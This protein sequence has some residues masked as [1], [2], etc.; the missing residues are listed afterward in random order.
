MFRITE[1]P[2][3]G[4]FIQCLAKNYS[5]GS[6]VSVDLDV[7]G[8][9]AAYCD[10]LCVCVCGCACVCLYIYFSCCSLCRLFETCIRNKMTKQLVCNGNAV[11]LTRHS[12]LFP[13]ETLAVL[14]VVFRGL[15]QSL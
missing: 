6:I 8:V 4:S 14:I 13:A 15:Y 5:N 1:D 7:V 9:M 10:P 2:S 12:F 3:S 11:V